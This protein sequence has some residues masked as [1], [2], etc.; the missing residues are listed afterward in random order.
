[1]IALDTNVLVRFLTR[2][3]PAQAAA[4]DRVIAGLSADEPGFVGR[5]VML[6]LVWVL[7]RAYRL[8]RA[9]V[10]AA[11]EGLLSAREMEVEATADIA[12]ALIR[13]GSTG[14]GFADLMIAAAARRAGA[15]KL[16]TFDRSA[17]R[18]EGVEL[19]PPIA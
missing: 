15:T 5:E 7:E 4:A 6:E 11:V 19:V 3:E 13:Y 9:E 1:V 18:I 14:P 17:A 10:I 8:P 16:V 2:D 12:A